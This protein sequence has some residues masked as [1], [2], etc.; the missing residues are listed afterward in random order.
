MG[1]TR[2][3]ETY[4]FTVYIPHPTTREEPMY[5]YNIIIVQLSSR[6]NTEV[7]LQASIKQTLSKY[8]PRRIK[9]II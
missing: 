1:I 8:L 3:H 7:E 5:Y 4:I 9:R 2:L 6:I